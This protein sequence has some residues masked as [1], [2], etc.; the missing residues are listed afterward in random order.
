MVPEFLHH[1][2]DDDDDNRK[3]KINVKLMF[4]ILE[5]FILNLKMRN[6][7]TYPSERTQSTDVAWLWTM[8]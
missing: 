3:I 7:S 1:D 5:I 6:C 8:K 4:D 2:D